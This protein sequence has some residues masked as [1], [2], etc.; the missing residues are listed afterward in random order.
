[1]VKVGIIED[2]PIVR[3]EMEEYLGMKGIKVL[4]SCSSI[5]DFLDV[6]ELGMPPEIILLDVILGAQNSLFQINK[7]QR[8]LPNSKIIVVTGFTKEEYLLQALN[9]GAHSYYLKGSGLPNL[10]E[11]IEQL[12]NGNAYLSPLATKYLIDRLQQNGQ[13][14]IANNEYAWVADKYGLNKR[15]IEVLNGLCR[16]KKYKEIASEIFLSINSVRHYVI[17]LYKKMEINKRSELIRKIKM[18]Q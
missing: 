14:A 17:L 13:C 9:N 6:L 8:M 11:A 18:E 4:Y 2:I 1:M 7:L 10:V 15:E 12:K 16:G 5:A 3:A